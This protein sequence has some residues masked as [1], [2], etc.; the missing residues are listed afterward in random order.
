MENITSNP[1]IDS[2]GPAV[3]TPANPG[4][5]KSQVMDFYKNSLPVILKKFFL[6]PVTGVFELLS[7][8]SGGNY[9]SSLVLMA[10]TAILYILLPYIMMGEMRDMISFGAMLKIGI[11]TVML[12]LL[13][14]AGTFV[15]KTFSGKPHFKNE[16]LTGALCGIPLSLM[17][18]ALFI[19][20]IFSKDVGFNAF[21]GG[22]GVMQAL[23]SAGLFIGLISVFCYLMMIN[24]I[25]QSLRAA[26]TNENMAWYIS[27]LLVMLAFYATIKIAGAFF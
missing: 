13:V 7:V 8:N 1:A 25:Q 20:N 5:D 27:P 18:I 12:M 14:S 16:L 23:Q 3:A 17:L 15:V 19:L 9:F 26:K 21:S 22:F 2:N 11:G 4:F 6:E 24:V 10:T